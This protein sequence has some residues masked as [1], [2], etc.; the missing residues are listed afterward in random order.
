MNY[1]INEFEIKKSLADK[2]TQAGFNVVAS[3]VDEGFKKPAV[4][5]NVLP[6]NVRLLNVFTEEITDTVDIKY[7]PSDETYEHCL[8]ISNTLKKL[9]LY[10]TLDVAK[11]KI[12]IQEIGFDI[13]KYVLTVSFDVVYQ[14]AT[15]FE[16][17]EYEQMENL[18]IGGNI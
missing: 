7:F 16:Q 3:E 17:E 18:Q 11:R 4:F 6:S 2:L 9:L 14:Q 12:T 15:S 10:N 1:I 5:I 13:E 8:L